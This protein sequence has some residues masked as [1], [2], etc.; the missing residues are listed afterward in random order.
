[1]K[2]PRITILIPCY[3]EENSILEVID[4]VKSV[5]LGYPKEIIVVDDGSEDSSVEKV[6]TRTGV[7]LLLHGKNQGKGK[8]IQ[9]GLKHAT[10]D[11]VVIQ[12]ADLEYF[13][14]DIPLLL[15]PL[16]KGEAD[17]VYGS[18]FLGKPEGMSFSHN[19]GNRVLSWA[20]R[21]LYG[22]SIT[23]MM[24]GYKAF[25]KTDLEGVSL[26]SRGFEFEPEIT[27][28]LLKK[29]KKITEV[30]ISYSYR[31]KGKA[32]IGWKDGIICF[33]WLIK[34]KFQK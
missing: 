13:P 2:K 8:A 28:K 29:G 14:K 5:D 11:I 24:T 33:W 17:V 30:P 6:K 20:T 32:K 3:N 27:V 10:G 19:I 4:M 21:I 26:E 22:N 7:K 9:T 34:G 23:D 31:K 25:F 16:I 18:R 12:D 15:A 1:M